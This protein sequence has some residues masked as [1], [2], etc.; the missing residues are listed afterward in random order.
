MAQIP[1]I[2][3]PLSNIETMTLEHM[4]NY[5]NLIEQVLETSRDKKMIRN[6]R[7]PRT[8]FFRPTQNRQKVL[9]KNPI[10]MSFSPSTSPHNESHSLSFSPVPVDIVETNP[11]S[12]HV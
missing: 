1:M 3:L 9:L 8:P 10:K 11:M 7:I 5:E 12:F 4:W 2:Q 6:Q